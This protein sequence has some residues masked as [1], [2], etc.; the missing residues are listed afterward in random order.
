M[1][2]GIL[3][4]TI[5]GIGNRESQVVAQH[6]IYPYDMCFRVILANHFKEII[7][8][9]FKTFP[10]FLHEISIRILMLFK[11][12]A[13]FR[14]GKRWLVK[15]AC[16]VCSQIHYNSIWFPGGKII[17]LLCTGGFVCLTKTQAAD[18]FIIGWDIM[19]HII[20]PTAINAP[21][22][23]GNNT[24]I[25]IKCF[26]S[27]SCVILTAAHVHGEPIGIGNGTVSTF[28]GSNTVT[29]KLNFVFMF[30]YRKEFPITLES[31]DEYVTIIV[32]THSLQL[33]EKFH[34]FRNA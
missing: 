25:G 22:A 13:S 16:I 21:A 11:S 2:S 27:K 10:I 6:T 34:G 15:S 19:T 32:F 12:F 30:L 7:Y 5:H 29:N 1:I 3:L 17:V 31:A 14:N 8:G 33:T 18:F 28:T 26:R 24:V 20:V 4:I 9:I 23:L